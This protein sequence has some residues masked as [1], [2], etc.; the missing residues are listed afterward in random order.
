MYHALIS[1]KMMYHLHV[2]ISNFYERIQ[3]RSM[4]IRI[5]RIY[6]TPYTPRCATHW[7]RKWARAARERERDEKWMKNLA[8][9]NCFWR[10]EHASVWIDVI[11]VCANV[12]AATRCDDDQQTRW[13]NTFLSTHL[14]CLSVSWSSSVLLPHIFSSDLID[15]FVHSIMIFND[16]YLAKRFFVMIPSNAGK[17][18]SADSE[19]FFIAA[20]NLSH[21]M[22]KKKRLLWHMLSG[23]LCLLQR[24]YFGLYRNQTRSVWVCVCV[25]EWI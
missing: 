1:H 2:N 12:T 5:Q 18:V 19:F 9:A 11:P 13:G 25:S 17:A 3:R 21:G 16:I 14:P 6:L 7:A 15:V 23:V 22:E 8:N 24:I 20:R 10:F 4:S